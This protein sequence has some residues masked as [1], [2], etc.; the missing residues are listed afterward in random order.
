MTLRLNCFMFPISYF[1]LLNCRLP[2]HLKEFQVTIQVS[3][4]YYFKS[5][6]SWSSDNCYYLHPDFKTNFSCNFLSW[7]LINIM[8]S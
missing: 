5:L 6:G 8:T 7:S 3:F 2:D 1:N 4:P